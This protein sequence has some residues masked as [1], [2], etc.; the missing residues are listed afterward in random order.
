[1]ALNGDIITNLNLTDVLAFHERQGRL[2]TVVAAPL[3][4][5]YGIIDV[6]ADDTVAGFREK[7]Q[8]PLWVNA[9]I[10]VLNRGIMDKLPDKGDHEELTFPALAEANGLMAYK[11][12]S[13]W[14]PVDNA[15]DLT[16]VR[17]EMQEL[18]LGALFRKATA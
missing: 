5:P 7:P 9:G 1:V 3:K 13:F 10:Y 11:S 17:S 14:R 18:F 8:L 4:S 2:A 15:N 6:D 12:R 16:E